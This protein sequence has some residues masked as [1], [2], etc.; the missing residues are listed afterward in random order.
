MVRRLILVVT[1]ALLT[2]QCGRSGMRGSAIIVKQE[3]YAKLT[4]GLY[5]SGPFDVELIQGNEPKLVIEADDNVLSLVKTEYKGQDLQIYLD[6]S[7]VKNLSFEHIRIYLTL[8]SI[9]A[10]YVNGPIEVN[11][12][13]VWQADQLNL[14]VNGPSDVHLDLEAQL[15]SISIDGP[16]IV[17]LHGKAIQ[18]SIHIRGPGKYMARGLE[19]NKAMVVIDGTGIAD[20]NV[21]SDLQVAVTGSGV[22]SYSGSPEVT[23]QINGFGRVIQQ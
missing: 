18:Q 5:A 17:A 2:V 8:P 10:L 14:F 22:V 11:S 13:G 1:V 21:R 4:S 15:L 19:S 12:H 7:A 3:R 23:S 9:D 20:L 16:S 6:Q